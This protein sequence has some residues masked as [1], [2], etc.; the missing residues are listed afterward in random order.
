[1]E[2]GTI[3]DGQI[4][5]SSQVDGRHTA[6]QGRLNFIQSGSKM[7]AWSAG[8][9]D[10]NQWLQIDLR[11]NN[12]I[13]TIVATQGKNAGD[14]WVTKYKLQYSGNGVSFHYYKEQG[15]NSHKVK[16]KRMAKNV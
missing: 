10:L 2:N 9:S 4:S 11:S 8:K 16:F 12:T 1:M 3:R 7:G 5:A 14:Q 13:V 15:Q 6:Q